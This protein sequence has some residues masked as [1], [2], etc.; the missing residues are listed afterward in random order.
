LRAAVAE[1]DLTGARDIA[2]VIDARIR[3]RVATLVPQPIRPWSE[4]VPHIADPKRRAFVRTVAQMMDARKQR[5][6]EHAAEQ[7]TGWA[8]SALGPVAQ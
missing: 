6:G 8:V 7:A 3:H 1:R 2:A 5:I 4:Q